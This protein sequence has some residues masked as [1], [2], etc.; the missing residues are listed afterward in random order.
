MQAVHVV[1]FLFYQRSYV[2]ENNFYC[3]LQIDNEWQVRPS[4]TPALYIFPIAPRHTFEPLWEWKF[5]FEHSNRELAHARLVG[6]G[7]QIFTLTWLAWLWKACANTVLKRK[8]IPFKNS[9]ERNSHHDVPT[10]SGTLINCVILQKGFPPSATICRS[11]WR[12]Y[13]KDAT[14]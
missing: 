13:R 14:E 10:E 1:T 2:S 9:E 7:L 5:L 4:C 12:S 8:E 11:G 6:R 3:I